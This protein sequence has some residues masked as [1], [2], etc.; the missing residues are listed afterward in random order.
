VLFL[1]GLRFVDDVGAGYLFFE[2]T[3]A[4]ACALAWHSYFAL[5]RGPDRIGRL[6]VSVA[7]GLVVMGV[8][9]NA[10]GFQNLLLIPMALMTGIV[11]PLWLAPSARQWFGDQPLSQPTR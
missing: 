5:R 7:A 2:L 11:A 4:A 8:L 3:Y 6:T 10:D 9:F 1:P